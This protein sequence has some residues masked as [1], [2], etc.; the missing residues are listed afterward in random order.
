MLS[1]LRMPTGKLARPFKPL[2]TTGD[3]AI[4]TLGVRD[5]ADVV[6]VGAGFAGLA[7]ALD[8]QHAGASVVV[9]EARE[10]VGG[11]VLSVELENGALAELGG[12]WIMPSD[13][14]GPRASARLGLELADA[15]VDYLRRE[16]RGR[17]AVPMEE[18]DTFL[19]AADAYLDGLD[20]PTASIDAALDAVPGDDRARAVAR[21]RLQ[22]T[23]AS[24]LS[25]VAWRAGWHAGRL[26]AEPAV[27]QRVARATRRSRVRPPAGC[28][29][30]GWGARCP[31]SRK[32][33]AASASVGRTGSS[34][35]GRRRGARSDRGA[36]GFDPPL[37][38]DQRTACSSSRWAWRRSSPFRSKPRLARSPSSAQM[39]RSGSGSAE[40]AEG[41]RG[42]S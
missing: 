28:P 23:F 40:V 21:A 19:E 6:V 36:L 14:I 18:L 7:A 16:P 9:L 8:L 2:S 3:L 39:R 27:Y 17:G 29:T 12:E 30:F 20:V 1:L 38:R 25:G 42:S 22:G 41:S 33:A 34:H 31:A 11:R 4:A 5:E 13:E 26:S 10:R 15:G 35:C 37:A 24:D 32:G